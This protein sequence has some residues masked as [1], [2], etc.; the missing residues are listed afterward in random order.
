MKT[1]LDFIFLVNKIKKSLIS[2]TRL[3][4]IMFVSLFIFSSLFSQTT[5]TLLNETNSL[6][7][8]IELLYETKYSK[9]STGA[10]ST[11]LG[12]EVKNVPTVNR[13]N[14]LSGRVTGFS[15]INVD[16][17][18]GIESS[19]SYV[20]GAH[21]FNGNNSPMILI[22]GR[23][24]DVRM[25]D[26]YDIESIT[27]LKDAAS[28]S[29]HG[30]RSAGGI[31]LIT[32]KKAD[33]GKISVGI[34]HQTSFS[35][36][37]RM[38]KFLN[39][40]NYATLYNEAM[41]NDNPLAGVRYDSTALEAYKTGNNSVLYP[42]T[43]WINNFIRDYSVQTRTNL[44]VKGGNNNSRFY[45]SVGHLYSN[46]LFNVDPKINNYNTNTNI[47]CIVIHGNVSVNIGENILVNADIRTKKDERNTPGAYSVTYDESIF[48]ALYS[49]PFNA[50][51]VFNPDGSLGGTSD[52]RNNIYGL[53]NHSG[54]SI[55]ENSSMSSFVD[56]TLNLNGVVN[57]LKLKG[58]VGLNNYADYVTN[59]TKDFAVYK[60]DADGNYTKYGMDSEIRNTGKYLNTYRNYQHSISLLYNRQFDKHIVNGFLMYER[61]QSN[62]MINK[63]RNLFSNYQGPKGKVSYNYRNAYL[64]DFVFAYQGSEQYDKKH[65]YGFFPAVSG[66]CILTNQPFLRESDVLNFLKVRFS[67]GLTGTMT[68][69]YFAYMESYA[70]G[71]GA[72]FGINPAGQTGYVEE[73]VANPALT[74]AKTKIFNAGIDASLIKNRLMLSID[75][76][77][78]K[79]SDILINNAISVMY[80]AALLTP[81]GKMDNKGY[82]LKLEWKERVNHFEYYIKANFSHAKNKIVY[83]DEQML[84]YPWMYRTGH[85]YHER[86]GYEFERFFTVDDDIANLPEQSLLGTQ[87]PG[88]FKYK[89]LNEDNIINQYDITSIGKSKIPE[90]S[91]G[92]NV[93]LSFKGFDINTLIQGI[94]GSTMYKYG[95]GYW[96]FY[97][98]IGNVQEHHF[99]RW[100]PDKGDAAKY[101][102]LT[103]SNANNYHANSFWVQDNSFIRLKYMEFGYTFSSRVSKGMGMSSLRFFLNGNNLYSWDKIKIVDPESQDDALSY[104]IQRTFSIGLNMQ[105]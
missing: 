21:T 102:R 90:L 83:Q 70:S 78:E 85:P 7:R 82:E 31:I 76:F 44:N 80:G 60:Y 45:V 47:N 34:N 58:L 100:T 1:K 52:Y 95:Y 103:L 24:D 91:Y 92:I 36:P 11:L 74:W 81:K 38:P 32:T 61:L 89:D 66:A 67:Y 50:Y 12:D 72:V 48:K 39:A 8:K 28:L 46:G 68:N 63:D 30:L 87:Q 35:M 3:V 94:A 59:R 27:V 23:V 99:E 15:L 97:N 17:L 51:P 101:P 42:N 75:M 105:F 86:F 41:L 5:D 13:I 6:N 77:S 56:A 57:G 69:T 9:L 79:T 71:T 29:L 54:Y 33:K 22:D 96:A 10:V 64:I 16:G 62:N 104:P 49:T 2:K 93:G 26:P 25:L 20:R 55:W 19:T 43:D 88:D 14:T 73:R 4:S 37:T 84:P 53:L 98:K 40:F 65:R 18:P